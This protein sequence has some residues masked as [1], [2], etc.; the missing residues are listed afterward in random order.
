M[1]ETKIEIPALL[2]C[3]RWNPERCRAGKFKIYIS[4]WIFLLW[5]S[6]LWRYSILFFV[7]FERT[8]LIHISIVKEWEFQKSFFRSLPYFYTYPGLNDWNA[9][10]RFSIES[11]TLGFS[12]FFEPNFRHFLSVEYWAGFRVLNLSLDLNYIHIKVYLHRT[13]HTIML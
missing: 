6:S 13:L 7:Y 8:V 10:C 11:S 1:T 9:C 12:S 5:I 3:E 2:S 4:F